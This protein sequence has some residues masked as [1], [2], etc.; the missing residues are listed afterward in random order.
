[1]L[2][3]KDLVREAHKRRGGGGEAVNFLP[4]EPLVTK[5]WAA[6]DL[7]NMLPR[8]GALGDWLIVVPRTLRNWK[9]LLA[10]LLG[11]P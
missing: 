8:V 11:M 6:R 10:T 2:K 7:W 9:E 4:R 5:V 3:K 1:M